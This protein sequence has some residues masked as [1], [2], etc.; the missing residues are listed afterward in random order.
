MRLVACALMQPL[1]VQSECSVVTSGAAVPAGLIGLYA[2]D[3]V[4][5]FQSIK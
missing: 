2:S 5:N 4:L 3:F 1:P